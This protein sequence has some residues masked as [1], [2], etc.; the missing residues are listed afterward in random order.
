MNRK[1]KAMTARLLMAWTLGAAL[2]VSWMILDR[3]EA[4]QPPAPPYKITPM[5][6]APLT[7][8]AN[9]ETIVIRVDFPPNVSTPWHTHAGDEYGTVLEGTLVSQREG[10]ESRKITAGQSYHHPAGVVHIAKTGD[11]PAKTI[12]VFVVEKGKPLLQPVKKK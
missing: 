3:S 2:A 6:K 11:Q 7:G 10:E 4:Q 12:N 9:K 5:L 8:D 1:E